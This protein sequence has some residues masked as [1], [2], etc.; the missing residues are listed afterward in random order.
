LL[1]VEGLLL[2]AGFSE[3]GNRNRV[4]NGR[5]LTIEWQPRKLPENE[6]TSAGKWLLLSTSADASADAMATG[7]AEALGA[8]D[9]RVVATSTVSWPLGGDHAAIA[10]AL[11]AQLDN[12]GYAGIVVLAGPN[13]DKPAES[14]FRGGD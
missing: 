4:R 10:E 6:E 2:G 12:S 9:S 11:R 14:A 8:Q 7:L 1:T 5:L 13:N 3:Q